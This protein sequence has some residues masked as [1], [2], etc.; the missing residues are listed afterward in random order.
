M[1]TEEKLKEMLGDYYEMGVPGSPNAAILQNILGADNE[2]RDPQSENEALLKLIYE[3]GVGNIM[4][5]AQ[6]AKD[7]AAHVDE[8]AATIPEDFTELEADV[9]E[10]K[11]TY[12]KQDGSYESL[13]AGNAEQLVSTVFVEDETP[14]NFRTSGGSADIG[15][16]EYDKIVGGSLAWNQL[17][18]PG[19]SSFTAEAGTNKTYYLTGVISGHAG[20]KVAFVS[21]HK[22]LFRWRQVNSM[23]SNIRNGPMFNDGSNHYHPSIGENARLSAGVYTWIFAATNTVTNGDIGIWVHTPDADVTYTD[24]ICFDI[25][26]MFGSAFAD[27]IYSLEQST[28]GAGVAWFRK[29]FPAAYYPYNAGELIS[30]SGLQSHDMTGFNQWD[31][32]WER[33]TIN[34]STGAPS[35]SNNDIRS[36]NFTPVLPN[37][38]YYIKIPGTVIV[39]IYDQDKN[40]LTYVRYG[41]GNAVFNTSKNGM[42]GYYIKFGTYNGSYGSAYNNDIC[43][44]LSWDGERNGEYEPY[45]LH[46]YPLDSSLTLRGIPK[47]DANNSLY[48]D[49]DTY[50]ADGTVVRKYEEVDLSTLEWTLRSTGTNNK[51][52]SASLSKNYI[53]FSGYDPELNWVTSADGGYIGGNT[54]STIA[55]R[56]ADSFSVGLYHYNASG[57]TPYIYCIT[58]VTD[59]PNGKLVYEPET[60]TTETAD[61]YQSPQ[62]VDDFGTEEYV[63]DSIVPVGHE[64]RYTNNLRAKL[65]MA[66]DSPDGDGD[67]I[68]RQT[69]GENAYVP[70]TKELPTAPTTDGTYV[71]KVTVTNGTP[72]YTWEVQA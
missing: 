42:D 69:N 34:P 49:G 29:L 40:F 31:E 38:Q 12:A 23:T 41:T 48:Y 27:Y 62:I 18:D 59:N 25:T 72:A 4:E 22:Y 43:I 14:Y 35:M 47:L 19:V 5:A 68:V 50:E 24:F 36:K 46:S 26:Q 39:D 60:P 67:Y 30:V 52:W 64:T 8:V 61:P 3:D 16:R 54:G 2:L 53:T 70:L 55:E 58:K 37:T 10:I 65:E 13:T 9:L 33:G 21:G 57:S 17:L 32:E 11:G 45:V 28:A 71:L 56:G 1:T 63:T 66:P 44:N 6:E 51:G 20:K 7:A 15:D